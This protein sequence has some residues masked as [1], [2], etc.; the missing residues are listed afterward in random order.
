MRRLTL[1]GR[2]IDLVEDLVSV[3]KRTFGLA[4]NESDLSHLNLVDFAPPR[5]VT[6]AHCEP[7]DR[8]PSYVRLSKWASDPEFGRMM[9]SGIDPLIIQAVA[10]EVALDKLMPLRESAIRAADLCT[11]LEGRSLEDWVNDASRQGG[12]CRLFLVDYWL[13]HSFLDEINEANREADEDETL[14]AEFEKI[15]HSGRALL[16]RR[17]DGRLVPVAI[18]LAY[19]QGEPSQ[20][21]MASDPSTVWL[22]A[23]LIFLS[24]QSGYHQ[25][26]SHFVRTHAC[27][28]PYLIALRRQL[29]PTHPIFRLL[30][31]H[32]RYTLPINAAARSLLINKGGVI[33]STFSPGS[34]SMRLSA[35]VYG[36]TWQFKDEGLAADLRKRGFPTSAEGLAEFGLE[37]PYAEDGLLIW[38]ALSE[39]F[40]DYVAYYY[41]SDEEVLE[42]ARLQ[43]WWNDVRANGHP[44]VTNGWIDLT[45]RDALVEICSTIA[46]VASAHHAAVNFGQ[47]DYSAWPVSHSSLCRMRAPARGSDA[48]TR[49]AQ[50]DGFYANYMEAAE[51]EL[52]RYVS[53]P[54]VATK[55]MSTV[56]LLSAHAEDEKY[57]TAEGERMEWLPLSQD[58]GLKAIFARFHRRMKE[59][60]DIIDKRNADSRNLART[61]DAG[62]LPY[63]LLRPTSEV[64]GVSFRGVPFSIS[65]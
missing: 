8:C 52:L 7:E 9:V 19:T 61:L 48:W 33:E 24:V 25:L 50:L 35:H 58:P 10:T 44:D 17:S 16:F 21:Y 12:Q 34:F 56:K 64:P 46:W 49:L 62:G 28:E 30:V 11:L 6:C 39:Y 18:E 41:K 60:D 22:A 29:S 38:D 5:S 57:L 40:S 43:A 47:Y 42:D 59:I 13:L 15:L 36:A 31:P 26:V 27:T 53:P 54:A 51:K 65:I 14:K 4:V 1:F 2:A 3:V 23:K 55:V 45:S 32:T 37:Y 63:T 20:L